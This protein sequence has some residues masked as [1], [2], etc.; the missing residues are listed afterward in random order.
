MIVKHSA[1]GYLETGQAL[2][3]ALDRR[4]LTLFARIDHAAAKKI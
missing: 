4:G 1:S 2:V 3:D